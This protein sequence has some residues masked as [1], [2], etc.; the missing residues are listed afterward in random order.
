MILQGME[1]YSNAYI[2]DVIVINK[3]WKHHLEE[4]KWCWIALKRVV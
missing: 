3:C 1:D 4:L 2:D